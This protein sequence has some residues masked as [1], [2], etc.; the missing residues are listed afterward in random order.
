M[1]WEGKK[2]GGGDQQ[3]KRQNSE[4]TLRKTGEGV[5]VR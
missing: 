3:E 1:G 2:K 4:G 5:K